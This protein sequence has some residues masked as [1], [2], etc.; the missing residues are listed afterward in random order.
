M[1]LSQVFE[2]SGT[3]ETENTDLPS[4]VTTRVLRIVALTWS[5]QD[6]ELCLEFE[7]LGCLAEPRE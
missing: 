1:F 6:E 7:A 5:P 2:R 4:P 3:H